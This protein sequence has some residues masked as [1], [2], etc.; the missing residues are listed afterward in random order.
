MPVSIMAE[1]I[2]DR[3][4]VNR[5]SRETILVVD[6]EPAIRELLAAILGRVGYSV[7]VAANA[8]EA[9]SIFEGHLTEIDL[10]ITDVWM[11]GVTGPHLVER[12]L[13]IQPGLKCILMSATDRPDLERDVPFLRKPFSIFQL[14][15]GV[16]EA[17]QDCEMRPVAGGLRLERQG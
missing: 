3:T 6:D 8:C 11:P 14:L 4:D 5:Q 9:A 1:S 2:L 16:V 15:S 7:L 13:S 17:L 12:L 10:I